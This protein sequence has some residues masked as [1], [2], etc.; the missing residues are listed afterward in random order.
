MQQA[1]YVSDVQRYYNEYFNIR[2]H[3]MGNIILVST[4]RMVIFVLTKQME[5][6]I[7]ILKV[8]K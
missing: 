3:L 6:K 1:L 7:G 4:Q 5:V 8:Y 2:R